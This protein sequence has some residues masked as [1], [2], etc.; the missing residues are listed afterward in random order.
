MDRIKIIDSKI[1]DYTNCVDSIGTPCR[2]EL[3]KDRH[4]QCQCSIV[5]FTLNSSLA[6]EVIVFHQLD[7]FNGAS[8]YNDTNYT[9]SRYFLLVMIPTTT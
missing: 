8:I 3:L 5:D 7:S 4:K 9:L 1:V 6:G 2:V